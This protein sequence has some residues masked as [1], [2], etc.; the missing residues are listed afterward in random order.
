MKREIFN[1]RSLWRTV[2][3]T[4]TYRLV[5]IFCH[6]ILMLFFSTG[7]GL[8]QSAIDGNTPSGLA[9]GTPTGAY[10]LSNLDN[11]NLFNG[12]QSFQLPLIQVDG[13]G[14]AKTTLM[15]ATN[16]AHWV[17]NKESRERG[18]F[19]FNPT[20]ITASL[21]PNPSNRL[22]PL[23]Q[24]ARMVNSR[25]IQ[26]V[27]Q[28]G[29]PVTT[30]TRLIVILADGTEYLL[31]DQ[32]TDGRPIK[33]TYGGVNGPPGPSRG[34]VFTS[35]DGS[36]VTFV[37]DF[38]IKDYNGGWGGRPVGTL[39]FPDGTKYR[40][41]E[42]D[43][44]W[45][46]DRNGN[47]VTFT[48]ATD[49][50]T[51]VRISGKV[52]EV[53]DS[54]NRSVTITHSDFPVNDPPTIPYDQLTFKGFGGG[55]RTVRVWYSR[56]S[57]ALRSGWAL[58][59]YASLFPALTPQGIVGT[60]NPWV[61][62]AVELPDGRRYQFYYNSYKELA[63]VELPTGGALE[64]D[65][66]PSGQDVTS[67]KQ[68]HR[69]CIERR[70]YVK[71]T[72]STP[73]SKQ[74]YSHT[75]T[76]VDSA[77][78]F[79]TTSVVNYLNP[80][81][82]IYSE[83][84]YF[85]GSATKAIESNFPYAYGG[86]NESRE[87]QVDILN[88]SGIT[89]KTDALT[90]QQA[91]PVSWWPLPPDIFYPGPD[92]P[93]N[94]P[95]VVETV[96][97]LLDTNLVS[98]KTSINPQTGIPAFDQF[99][100]RTDIW[101]FDY[102]VGAP[103]NFLRRTH[104]DYVSASNYTSATTGVHLRNLPANQWISSDVA[105]TNKASLATYVYDQAAL[106]DCPGIIGFDPAFTTGFTTRGNLTSA[107]R[108]ADAVGGTGPVTAS[109]TYD[110]AGN[111]VSSTDPLGNFTQSSF[112]DSFS[113]GLPRNTYAFLTSTTSPIPD[114]TGQFGSSTSLVSASVYDFSTGL[115]TSTTDHNS[116]TTTFEYSDVL[117][118]ITRANFP[119]G[120][121]T[122][123]IYV[124]AHQCG[125]YVETRTLLDSTEREI[126]SF[127]FFDGLGRSNRSFTLD[128]QDPSN[129]WLTLDTQYDAMGRRWRVS[130]PYRSNGCT[131]TVNP[132]NR[133]TETTFDT[134]GR[135]TQVRSTSDNSIVTNSYVG[136]QVTVMD[137]AGKKRR[138]VLDVLGRLARLDEP[139]G[140]GNLDVSG[141]PVQPT[142]YTYDALGNLRRV[143]QGVQQRFYMFDSLSRMIRAKN[144]EQA[145]VPAISNITDPVSSNSQW[146]VAYGYDA[147]GNLT[148]R[149]DARNITTT[150]GHDKLNRNT[151]VRY[152]DGVTK[153]I[154]RHYDGAIN[155]RGRFHYFNWDPNNNTRWETH[156]AIDEYD[157]M[158][159]VKKHRQHFFT[160]G[161]AGP[162]FLVTRNYDLAGNVISQG[163]PSGR[164]V[165]YTYDTAGRMNGFT[166]NLGDGATRTY[167][168]SISYDE[169]GGIRQEQ[170]GTQTPLYHKR[171]YNPRG[172]LF[173]I[174]L[175]TIA[176]ATDQWNWNRGAIVNYFSSNFAWE[177]DPNTPAGPDNN[178]NLMRQQHWV[179]AD[180]A[181]SNY[182]YTQDT[183]SYDSLSRLQS[184]VELH[185]TPSDQSG[186]DY[187]QVFVYD[188]WGNRTISD[189][190][191]VGAPKPQFELSPSTNQEL[192]EPSNR[193]YALGDAGRLPSQKLM[194]YDASGNLIYDAFTG[195]GTRGYDAENRMTSAQDING[196]TTN[197]VYDADGRR[198]KRNIDGVVTLQ[199]HG[200]G[201]E[202]LAEYAPNAAANSPQK[203]YGFRG[204]ELLVSATSA[205]APFAQNVTWA[206][207]AGVNISGNTLTKNT[208]NGWGNSGAVS[209][210][211]IASGDGY[212]EFTVN[213]FSGVRACGL[214][215]GDSNL[216]YTDIDFAVY[217]GAFS[218]NTYSVYEKGV[219]KQIIGAYTAGDR[220]RVAVES[221]V[222]KYYRNGVL[223]YT[224]TAAPVYPL[225]VDTAFFTNTYDISNVVLT[226]PGTPVTLQWLVSDHLGT[227]RM[228]AD[229]SGSLSGIRR[230][231]HLPFGEELSAGTGGR[232]TPQGYSLNDNVRQKFTGKE[233]DTE[234]G[235]DYFVARYYSSKQGRFTSL[236]PSNESIR[237]ENPQSFNRYAYCLNNPLRLVDRDGKIPVEEVIDVI[238][239][240]YDFYELINH[241]SWTNAGFFIWDI[242]GTL[243]PYAPG[244][245]AGR[246]LKWATRAEELKGGMSL[247]K[248]AVEWSA[249][250]GRYGY[251]GLK[252][253]GIIGKLE[254]ALEI[255]ANNAYI[256]GGVALLAQGDKA[257]RRLLGMARIT[258]AADFVGVTKGGWY[259]IGESKGI[260]TWKGVEQL[261][262]T[263]EALGNNPNVPRGA[264]LVPE[265]IVEDIS[266][267]SPG[268]GIKG[269]ELFRWDD[270]KLVPV[271]VTFQGREV[272]IQ[273]RVLGM[274]VDR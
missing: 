217:F 18:G 146:S 119:D 115:V 96:T 60:Y 132:S 110:I 32:L 91:A 15:L 251:K 268:Y 273:V 81:S 157:A 234:T 265:L 189:V 223:F 57:A 78:H 212:V 87:Y 195:N 38:E 172:Q 29:L 85:F 80:T 74:T 150:Y 254:N 137:Q 159:R 154:D 4:S 210:Q 27:Q 272:Q 224:S 134:L 165:S 53:K 180:D 197:Y 103:G 123:Y 84:H 176:W 236:D 155:G 243:I 207:A 34:T 190:Q 246:G 86:W 30:L 139:D 131:T 271:T 95:R 63:R 39:M 2:S 249:Q 151:T 144:P 250:V 214:S 171:H 117:D 193:L 262:A 5:L 248:D 51:G 127:Q 240:A 173:D 83:K 114:P 164:T 182:N 72:D 166:G 101:E 76:Q 149:I 133:W 181:I 11:V 232:T 162:Q 67:N 99:H 43:L 208:A 25:V 156:L 12:N 130:N 66:T 142:N 55:N 215:L 258:S 90:W 206:N 7:T 199:I 204:K 252:A 264:T 209:T 9:A 261:R 228:V 79:I 1:A 169:F 245:W 257:T 8:A 140:N 44:E 218:G 147:N 75:V 242:A 104:T 135:A 187:A 227:P 48:Y 201:G 36:S 26:G 194:R 124:D 253:Q 178:G 270:R 105:G 71:K 64:Y 274:N 183:F 230:R 16:S 188:R 152:S 267:I 68:I 112:G 163:Y 107:T 259:I 219:L 237:P 46:R 33:T 191:T 221:G 23:Y 58:G 22:P 247:T 6:A 13:R 177:G 121:R 160:N 226:T 153:D 220:F 168:T 158:G 111:A 97:T 239:L 89:I 231:D 200:I 77:P 213:F 113:D 45:I 35:S 49:P 141:S 50:V 94:N 62:Q 244:S 175:S 59:T 31:R 108:F 260:D 47:K 42:G 37:S 143:Q 125:P 69:R 241:P 106:V 70:T 235:L 102:A 255:A 28:A 54:L 198:V 192:P 65:Y 167:S 20:D 225:L 202:L 19:N 56:L 128:N 216:S 82:L 263:A 138:S 120:G 10:S 92:E 21:K 269:N 129:P 40:F 145:A 122:T 148:S 52:I 98:K 233:R 73:T 196:G 211:S 126:D 136:N 3:T 93:Q 109:S 116:K 266:K 256:R 41:N 205:V 185:G 88:A 118:R 17:V 61:V 174:R 24:P 161:V 186:Q 184:T 179:P 14:G 229:L 238:V 222:V 203:E 100:N 170:F